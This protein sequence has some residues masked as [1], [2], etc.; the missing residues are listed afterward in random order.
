MDVKLFLKPSLIKIVLTLL[1]PLTAWHGFNYEF[2]PATPDYLGKP[3]MIYESW[4]FLP[5]PL[6]LTIPGT[7]L[8]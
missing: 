1:I 5:P 3:N 7:I 6:I 8:E 2:D 4:E